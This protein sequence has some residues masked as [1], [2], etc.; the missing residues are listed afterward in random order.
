LPPPSWRSP[1]WLAPVVIAA[2]AAWSA[3][4]LRTWAHGGAFGNARLFNT[5][6]GDVDENCRPYGIRG[7]NGDAF[8]AL[9]R[10]RQYLTRR[11]R[12]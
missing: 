9:M 4:R 8:P 3:R 6:D 5:G 10:N 2:M 1:P 12:E 7:V 11:Y